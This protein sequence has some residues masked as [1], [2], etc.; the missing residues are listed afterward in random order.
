[1]R[2]ISS[3]KTSVQQYVGIV[4]DKL[5][6]ILLE[7]AKNPGKPRFN[8]FMFESFACSIRY[9]ASAL[10]SHASLSLT[11]VPW[12]TVPAVMGPMC[13]PSRALKRPCFRLSTS[14]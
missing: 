12:C 14:S 4:V 11:L 2:V 6:A 3:A 8:H 9:V 1:M 13:R 7:V 10:C 5:S